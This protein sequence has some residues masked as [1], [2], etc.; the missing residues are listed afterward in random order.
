MQRVGNAF[1]QENFAPAPNPIVKGSPE[2]LESTRND[3]VTQRSGEG[4]EAGSSGEAD[5]LRELRREPG[6]PGAEI[7]GS[8]SRRAGRPRCVCFCSLPAAAVQDE[9]SGA[10]AERP[11]PV[12]LSVHPQRRDSGPLGLLL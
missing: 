12:G 4:G 2:H 1:S 3:R 11:R 6:G 7:W 9:G 10:R 8:G 5:L